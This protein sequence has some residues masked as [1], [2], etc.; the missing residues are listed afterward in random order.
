MV[1][2][3]CGEKGKGKTK[4]LLD[5]VNTLVKKAS[6]NV[7]YIDKDAK[8]MYELSNKIRL[9]NVKEFPITNSDEFIGFI[10]GILSQDHDL[11]EMFFDS[12]LTIAKVE[13]GEIDHVI[14]KL[15]AISDSFHVNF[16]ISISKN[17]DQLSDDVK[18][19]IVVDL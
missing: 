11:E 16:V 12:F 2:I 18:D 4:H 10:C 1:Q 8:K 13:D 7:V 6:G 14:R 17:S 3:I 5:R 15:A 19:Y 9:I